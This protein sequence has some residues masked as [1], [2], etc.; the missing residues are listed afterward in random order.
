MRR[1]Y[2]PITLISCAITLF[3]KANFPFP[4]NADYAYGI[5]PSSID[6]DKVQ[7]AYED[8]MKLYEENGEMA[9]IKWDT[10][11]YTVSEGIGYG[12]MILVYMDNEENN[13]QAKFDKLWKYYNNFLDAKGLMNWKIKGFTGPEGMYDRNSATDAELDVGVGLLAAYKQWGDEKYLDDARV[14]I[15]KIAKYE[16]DTVNYLLN[17]GDSWGDQYNPSYFSTAALQLFKHASSFD[18]DKVIA[19]SYS[20]LKKAQNASTGLVPDWCTKDGANAPGRTD[21]YYYDAARTPWRIAWAHCWYGHPEA[22]E[23]CGKIS[24]WIS[25]ETGNDASKVVDGYGRDGSKKGEYNNATFVGPFACAG[26]VDEAHQAWLDAAYTH[27]NTLVDASDVYYQQS[28]K[29]ITLLLLSGNMPDLWTH[30]SAREPLYRGGTAGVRDMELRCLHTTGGLTKISLSLD[31]P[32][33]L[34]VSLHD[35]AG[36][37]V[38]T[39]ASGFFT[40]GTHQVSP[41]TPF[42]SGTYL[43]RSHL[44]GRELTEKI[45]LNR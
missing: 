42:S 45:I 16:V 40:A 3:A 43:V 17:P 30:T 21:Q 38:A 35:L 4:Q 25:G 39:L 22:K 27:M 33:N 41:N 5:M 23:I 1:L 18:W 8:F 12:M 29:V 31:K 13:T 26:L 24:T 44:E 32:A 14:F 37:R 19:N 9:R 36:K 15:E 10:P 34:H 6:A 11:D 20:L 28:L 7:E 2:F